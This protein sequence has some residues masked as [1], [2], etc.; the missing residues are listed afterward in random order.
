MVLFYVASFYALSVAI[1]VI[2]LSIAYAIWGGVGIILTRHRLL[3]AVSP[4]PGRRRPSSGI[5][6]IVSGGRG[7]QTCSRENT[8]R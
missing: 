2:P 7:H 5:A 1:R 8:V 3:R 4:D 6:L